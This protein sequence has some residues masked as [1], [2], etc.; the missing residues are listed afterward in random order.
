MRAA[1]AARSIAP[2]HPSVTIAV[3]GMARSKNLCGVSQQTL[4]GTYRMRCE[5]HAAVAA[6]CVSAGRNPI[7]KPWP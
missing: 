3:A 1:A 5:S 4:T 6:A 7:L 2:L